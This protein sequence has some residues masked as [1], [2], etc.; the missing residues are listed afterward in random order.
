VDGVEMTRKKLLIISLSVVGLVAIGIVSLML[1][2]KEDAYAQPSVLSIL[3]GKALVLKAGTNSWVEAQ[4]GHTLKEGDVIR[5]NDDSRAEIT[6]FEGSTIELQGG[7]EIKITEQF[8]AKNETSTTISLQ[9]ELG[10]TV[11]R[12]K[13]LADPASRYE[14]STPSGVAAVRGTTFVVDVDEHGTAN[15]VNQEGSVF[16]IAQGVEV[17][18][19]EGMESMMVP[20]EAPSAPSL[21][22]GGGAGSI[23]ISRNIMSQDAN[24]ITYIYEVV[25]VGDTV[26]YNVIVSDDEVND[27]EYVRGDENNNGALDPNEIWIFTGTQSID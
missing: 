15:V 8:L 6:F 24:I 7:T 26:Q 22:S 19:P 4:T 13:K 27:I 3:E 16:A 21:Y 1:F 14:I 11:S 20:G 18:I 12:V 9:Q 23:R 5:V 17:L 10:K 2:N 25:N